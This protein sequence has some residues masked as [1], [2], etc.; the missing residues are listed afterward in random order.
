MGSSDNVGNTERRNDGPLTRSQ[1]E[2]FEE[3]F[4]RFGQVGE[5]LR[6]GFP[7]RRSSGLG[8]QRT[9]TALGGRRD[10][11]SQFHGY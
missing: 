5:C 8:I 10:D 6:L 7:L 3:K 9:E 1:R 4:G 2:L 11:R